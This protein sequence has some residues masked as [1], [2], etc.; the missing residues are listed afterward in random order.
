MAACAESRKNR[1]IPAQ[2]KIIYVHDEDYLISYS[3]DLSVDGMFIYTK[4]PVPPGET[5]EIAFSVGAIDQ[6]TVNARVIWI[7]NSGSETES[8][9]GVQFINPPPSFQE[10]ILQTVN[11]IAVLFDNPKS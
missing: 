3:K 7:K 1:R 11:R 2:L 9:M 4:N 5:T 10:S 6:L 8:G